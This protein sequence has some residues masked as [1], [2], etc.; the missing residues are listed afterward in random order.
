M[1]LPVTP[2]VIKSRSSSLTIHR[3]H[4]PVFPD[5]PAASDARRCA[6]CH[7]S[8]RFNLAPWPIN[9]TGVLEADIAAGV[10]HVAVFGILGERLRLEQPHYRMTHRQRLVRSRS[11]RLPARASTFPTAGNELTVLLS[12]DTR[13]TVCFVVERRTRRM[14]LLSAGSFMG[15]FV[16]KRIGFVPTLNS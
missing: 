2:K 4:P 3:C 6:S 1:P 14:L 7:T 9:S 8:R 10:E 13:V 16:S 5:H 12:H 11:S 15:W